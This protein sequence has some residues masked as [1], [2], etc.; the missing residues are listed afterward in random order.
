MAYRGPK[1]AIPT[2]RGWVHEQTGELLKSQKIPQSFI[3]EWHGIDNTPKVQTLHEAP[4]VE[5]EVD[6]D[7]KDFY[8]DNDEDES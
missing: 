4:V 8:Y 2:S 6:E 3:D 7:L 1:N 5:K